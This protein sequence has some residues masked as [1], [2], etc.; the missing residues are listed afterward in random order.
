MSYLQNGRSAGAIVILSALASVG[1]SVTRRFRYLWVTGSISM[2]CLV[3]SII[4]FEDEIQQMKH[5]ATV[6][7]DMLLARLD[8]AAADAT[9][10]G[11]GYAVLFFGAVL[12]LATAAIGTGKLQFR[13]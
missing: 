10:L 1:L 12:L 2:L 6:G 8:S 13:R 9:Q 3:A 4:A 5:P 11:W 7:K